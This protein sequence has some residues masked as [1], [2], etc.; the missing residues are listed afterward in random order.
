LLEAEK[1]NDVLKDEDISKTPATIEVNLESQI[2]ES[3]KFFDTKNTG[4]VTLTDLNNY[5]EKF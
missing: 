4:M 1:V 2:I 3:I 5:F